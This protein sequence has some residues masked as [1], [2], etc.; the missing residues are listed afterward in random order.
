MSKPGKLVRDKIPD[1]IRSEGLEPIIHTASPDE[2][3]E[4]L[5]DKLREE[6]AELLDSDTDVEELTD[7]IEVVY[8]RAELAGAS[9]GATG[10]VPSRQ[11]E[12]QWCLRRP[13]RLVRKQ[14]AR[15]RLSGSRLIIWIN[16]G[17]GAGKTSLAEELRRRLP[18]AVLFDPE[19]VGCI[20]REWVPIPTG[21]FQDLPCWRELVIETAL[22]LRR[23]HAQTLLVPMSL[24]NDDYARQILGGLTERGEQIL[25][26]FLDLYAEVLRQRITERVMWPDH[27]ERNQS[28]REFCFRNLDRAIA[29]AGRQPEETLTLRSDKM[30]SSQLA[31]EILVLLRP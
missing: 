4:R 27:P 28:A 9:R 16:G 12:V 25:H 10:S 30:N 3:A 24:L 14:A 8:A 19:Y 6:V 2:Y 20:L 11:G 18:G 5:L 31:D 17:F 23:H 22:A 7:I 15:P 26:V 21:D 1:L 29:A 13:A